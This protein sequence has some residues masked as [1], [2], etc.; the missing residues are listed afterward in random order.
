LRSGTP[1]EARYIHKKNHSKMVF[2]SHLRSH[3]RMST[4]AC[5]RRDRTLQ[6]YWHRLLYTLFADPIQHVYRCSCTGWCIAYHSGICMVRLD[7]SRVKCRGCTEVDVELMKPR[8]SPAQISFA[9]SASRVR[10]H[11]DTH[12][13]YTGLIQLCTC[14]L[15][16][17][18]D[19]FDYLAVLFLLQ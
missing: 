10:S 16:H 12:R 4:L 3:F 5:F 18:G 2:L 17:C 7:Q 11:P 13:H 15:E 6:R 19:C 8:Q 9:L 14:L 1:S